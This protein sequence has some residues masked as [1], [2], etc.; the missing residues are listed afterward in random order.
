MND[1][2]LSIPGGVIDELQQYSGSLDKLERNSSI[3]GHIDCG[4]LFNNPLINT[5]QIMRLYKQ[6]FH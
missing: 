2:K 1:H 4:R 6:N 5:D 3:L